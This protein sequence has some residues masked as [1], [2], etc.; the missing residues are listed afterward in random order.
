MV[1]GGL[2][3]AITMKDFAHL[4]FISTVTVS[5]TSLS[6]GEKSFNLS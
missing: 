1:L 4:G 3:N 2:Y 6:K 5:R